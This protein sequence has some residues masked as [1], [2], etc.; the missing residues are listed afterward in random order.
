[1]SAEY[2][3]GVCAGVLLLSVL[4]RASEGHAEDCRLRA[5]AFVAK[6]IDAAFQ[7][8]QTTATQKFSD[9]AT[10]LESRRVVSVKGVTGPVLET[11][12]ESLRA[13]GL[14]A[15]SGKDQIVF[16]KIR[17]PTALPEVTDVSVWEGMCD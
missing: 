4:G 1:V 15:A 10:L 11:R 17:V 5:A 16:V 8:F 14:Y 2:A 9:L 6:D 13:R 7:V 12:Q 3:V